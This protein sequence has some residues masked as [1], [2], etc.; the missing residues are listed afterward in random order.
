MRSGSSYRRPRVRLRFRVSPS[1]SPVSLLFF[2]LCISLC[3]L[4]NIKFFEDFVHDLKP[5]NFLII[6]FSLPQITLVACKKLVS[7][8]VFDSK[9]VNSYPS[10]FCDRIG[11]GDYVTVLKIWWKF[12]NSLKEKLSPRSRDSWVRVEGFNR[13]MAFSIK[14]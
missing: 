3:W 6:V 8:R 4:G 13:V 11:R 12:P 1:T 2:H 10:A 14:G 9:Y 5:I 7:K